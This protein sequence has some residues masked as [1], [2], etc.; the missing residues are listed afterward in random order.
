MRIRL[1]RLFSY[2]RVTVRRFEQGDGEATHAVLSIDGLVCSVCAARV[3]RALSR[4]PGAMGAEVDLETG[5][6]CVRFTGQPASGEALAEA[7]EGQVLLRPAR[8]WL[9]RLGKGAPT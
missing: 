9:A 5:A 2:P 7:V 6:A 3:Q 1:R 8:R 4:L